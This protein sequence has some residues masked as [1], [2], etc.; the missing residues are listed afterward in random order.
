MSI[1]LA[2]SCG[3]VGDRISH[4][5]PS[6]QLCSGHQ[7]VFFLIAESGPP[8]GW[9]QDGAPFERASSRSVEIW[10]SG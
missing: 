2:L 1:D 5:Y 10:I 3:P 6:T 7:N 9:Q 4:H 8:D